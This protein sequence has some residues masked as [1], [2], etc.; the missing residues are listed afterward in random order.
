MKVQESF[1]LN[2]IQLYIQS[3]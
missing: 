2:M 3:W 1:T